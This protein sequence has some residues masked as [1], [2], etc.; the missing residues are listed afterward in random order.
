MEEWVSQRKSLP[1]K[2]SKMENMSREEI[3][4]F[5]SILAVKH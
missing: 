3:P 2:T 4:M 1:G 5:L